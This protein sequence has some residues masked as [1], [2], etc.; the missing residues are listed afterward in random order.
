MARDTIK[1]TFG[2]ALGVCL[3]CSILVSGAAVSLKPTQNVN[4]ALDKK[5]NILMAAGLLGVNESAGM[6][7]VQE[8]YKNID[9]RVIDLSTGNYTDIDPSQFDGKKSAKD[10]KQ[11]V[12]ILPDNDLAGIKT[13]SKYS[14]VYLVSDRGRVRKVIL[15]VNGKGLWSTLYGF[16]ALDTK[17]LNTIR[18]LVFYEHGET[19]GLGGEVDNPN[20][21]ALWNGKKAF[22]ED[23]EVLIDVIK[24]QVV[25]GNPKAKYQV[26]GL[27]GAT[28]TA[29]GV[30]NMLRY[31]LGKEG[32]DAYIQNLRQ[33]GVS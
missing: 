2:V 6:S 10:P 28:I 26:D 25:P 18:G 8:L 24:G 19:P 13:R 31:W 33:Q 27:S 11:S 17:D 30:K 15:P 23:G 4:K 1:D 14:D 5:R 22:G 21:K 16:L 32:F 7:R 20:W 3:V 9:A 29:N 12:V